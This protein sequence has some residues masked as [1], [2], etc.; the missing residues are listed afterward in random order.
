[1]KKEKHRNRIMNLIEAIP[2]FVILGA[3]L[4]GIYLSHHI[5]IK[6]QH[7]VVHVEHSNQV[8]HLKNR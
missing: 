8:E 3:L 1:M 4:I 7:S 2:Y 6:P 5:D